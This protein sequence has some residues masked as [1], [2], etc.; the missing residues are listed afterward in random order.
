M[1]EK[2]IN[3]E[4]II[5]NAARVVFQH[6][7]FDG[8]RMQ[9]IADEAKINKSLLH[10][11]YRSKELLFEAI[12]NEALLKFIPKISIVLSS[13]ISLEMKVEAFV[14]SYINM[15]IENPFLPGFVLNEIS[16]NPEKIIGLILQLGVNPNK[17]DAILQKEIEQGKI[18]NISS[19]EFIVNL[20][21]MCVFPFIAKAIIQGFLFG[22]NNKEAQQFLLE[23]KKS[24][25]K[26]FMNAI[27]K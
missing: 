22:N 26:F 14:E 5:L 23:R 25:P 7:G 15:L 8:A 16:R 20:I 18:K 12:F 9:E 10:Y 19:K 17:L 21:S 27:K 13:D 2:N 6:K 4:T 24:I 1:T 11:Y 3:T